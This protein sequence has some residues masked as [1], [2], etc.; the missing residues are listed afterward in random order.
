LPRPEKPRVNVVNK[1]CSLC[2]KTGHSRDECW[3]K[4]N[5]SGD[6]VKTQE[7]KKKSRDES[8]SD[9]K[10]QRH[11]KHGSESTSSNSESEPDQ[12][13]QRQPRP[14]LEYRVTHIKKVTS[15]PQLLWKKLPVREAANGKI[16]MLYNS[17][18]TISLIKLKQL[19]D[20]ALIYENKIAL[21]GI[22][23]HK[24]YTI[25][26]MH[27]TIELDSRRLKHA[28]YV[29]GDDT[30]IEHEGILGIDFLRK[31]TV[32]CDYSKSRL[33]IGS[34][35]LR[36]HPFSKL[37]LKPRSETILKATTNK[38][39]VGIVRAE[40][41]TPGVYIGNCLVNARKYECPVSIINTTD[42]AVEITTPHVTIEKVEHDTATI[43][44]VQTNKSQGPPVSRAERI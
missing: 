41:V 23:G 44:T 4:R 5:R 29:I 13:K 28:F 32:T 22:T 40:E 19:R 3:S 43:H 42:K 31:H 37:T 15:V 25:G 34:A 7:P 36:L 20:D 9:K 1:F 8:E 16:N 30:P 24:V 33:Q 21:I 14:A 6:K 27:A 12:A 35:I 17:G 39:K 10:K 26:K 38:N 18:S 2:K 11:R